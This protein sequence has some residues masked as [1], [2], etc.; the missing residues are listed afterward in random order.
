[1]GACGCLLISAGSAHA[2]IAPTLYDPTNCDSPANPGMPLAPHPGFT[3]WFC[4]DGV[5]AFGGTNPNP[6]GLSAVTVPAKYGGDGFTGLPLK[7]ADAATMPGADA[8]GNVALDVDVT[9]PD[10]P[11]PGGGYPLV[12]MMHGCC[13]GDKTGWEATSFDAGGER[14]HYSNA[15]FASRGYVVVNYTARGFVNGSNQGSTGQTQLDSRSFEI[16]DFQSLACQVFANAAN[17][18]AANGAAGFSIDPDGVVVTGGSY[19]GGF[20]WLAATD[21]KWTCNV[22]DTGTN[23][24]MQLAAAAPK[25]GW[26]DL[27]YTLVPN[28]LHSE[29]PSA[30]PLTNGCTTGPRQLD[31]SLC[32]APQAPVGMPKTSIVGALYLSGQ[33]GIPPGSN[34]TTFSNSITEAFT[35]LQGA[36]PFEF[37]PACG[38]TLA[39]IL[40]EFLRERSAYYQSDF[41]ANIAGDP[42]YRVPIFNAGTLTDPLFPAYENRRMANR[43][44]A[45]VPGYPIKQYYGDYQHFVQNKAK[46][47]GDLCGGDHHVCAFT[48]YPGGDVNIDPGGLARV[49]VTTRL[50][51][52]IDNFAQPAGGYAPNPGNVTQDVTASL[53]VCPDN[54]AALGTPGDEPGATFTA[55]AFEALAPNNLSAE[56]P[57]AQDTTSRVAAN[58]HAT[59][60]DPIG[61]FVSNGGR[62]PV[63]PPPSVAGVGVASYSTT[64]L[65]INVTTIGATR[66]NV[67]FVP[68]AGA[69]GLEL[70]VRLYDVFPPGGNNGRAVM[71]D[72]GPHRVTDGE[73]A[74]GLVSFELHG[75][76]WQFAAGHQIRIEITQDDEPFVKASSFPSST[77]LSR[78]HFD[79]PI[80]EPSFS[81]GG[82]PDEKQACGNAIA[83]T[84]KADRLQG[85]RHGDRMKG[86]KG[87]DRLEGREGDDCIE[88]EAADDKLKG[89][90]D[91][92]QVIGG[93]DNDKVVGG[94][95]VDMLIG[96]SGNDKLKAKDGE[97]DVVKCGGGKDKA[98]ADRKD[99]VKGCEKVRRGGKGKKGKKKKRKKK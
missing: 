28:G 5:P 63:Q 57:G 58:S 13:A 36:Y 37:N 12:F 14:W 84:A 26:T 1:V 93:P 16:N 4:N 52:F 75:N 96:G 24:A 49:G 18:D 50:N 17:F 94:S 8:A 39:T 92:D 77:E 98:K 97:R 90:E 47:W 59:A 6:A 42:S 44:L 85:T 11:P 79:M 64:P 21:P 2:A 62:C 25:Y 31:G 46:E 87:K 22:A 48:D 70:D 40:P 74:G 23:Q 55:G 20:S 83:A 69:Q 54:A 32:A 89:G 72:R 51:K 33:T 95:G 80:R 10:T 15:W 27:A 73:L 60:A 43:L 61:N 38:N 99:R 76:G 34:H 67:S 86:G 82:G 3:Y 68:T 9:M 91:D 81:I 7:A 45:T 56:M 41:F 78:A 19:G 53:Q 66:V 29:L 30:L 35:C 65:P 71:V 88:G